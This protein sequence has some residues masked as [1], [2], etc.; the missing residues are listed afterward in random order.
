MNKN[1]DEKSGYGYLWHTG[2]FKVQNSDINYILGSGFGSHWIMIIKKYN[3]VIV[4][5][6]GGARN[7][8]PTR[9]IIGAIKKV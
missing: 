8:D 4:F 9:L 7:I 6:C 3:L 1:N 2:S 5:N